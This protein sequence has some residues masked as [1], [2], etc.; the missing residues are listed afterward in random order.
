MPVIGLKLNGGNTVENIG[1]GD[2]VD[3]C[4][5]DPS[6]VGYNRVT[7]CYNNVGAVFFQASAGNPAGNVIIGNN[8]PSGVIELA[9]TD[10]S[11]VVNNQVKDIYLTGCTRNIIG[12]NRVYLSDTHGIHLNDSNDNQVSG[13]YVD[14]A[15]Q[16]VDDTYDGIYV[17]GNSDRNNITD[18][19]VRYAA[20]G[21]RTRYGV[22]ISASTCDEN[23]VEDNDLLNSGLTGEYNDSGS[24]TRGAQGLPAGAGSD[25]TAIHDDTPGEISAVT[26]KTVPVNADLI[27]IEDS[28]DSNNKKRVQ[29]GNLPGGASSSPLTTKGD[30]FGFSTVDARLPVGTDDLVLTADSAETL[31]VKWATASR[32]VIRDAVFSEAGT[33]TTGVGN[34]RLYNLSGVTRTIVGCYVGVGTAP[35]GADLIVDVNRDGTTIFTTQANRPTIA[36]TT[37]VSALETPDV[38][39]W[40]DGTYLTVDKD[41]VGSTVAG[42]DLVVTVL[43]REA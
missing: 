17:D 14:S 24:D 41:Q 20:T 38:T 18:N 42:A 28:A 21:N 27:I 5:D 6:G 25:P 39:S 7:S 35:T 23:L 9:A 11:V 33:L 22:N 16:T 15:G 8:S 34:A 19:T 32:T 13:N 36:A 43:W 31:G 37:F 1:F 26:E 2:N 12:K 10:R 4:I 29:L 40:G 3:V 30:L